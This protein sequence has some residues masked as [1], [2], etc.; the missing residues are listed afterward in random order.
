MNYRKLWTEATTKV[1]KEAKISQVENNMEFDPKLP[2]R[3][4]LVFFLTERW[5]FPWHLNNFEK[6]L[7]DKLSDFQTNTAI[8]IVPKYLEFDS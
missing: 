7:Y 4:D 3:H 5:K 6:S 8:K 1:C 2:K